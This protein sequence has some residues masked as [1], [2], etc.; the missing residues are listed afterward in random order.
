MAKKLSVAVGSY[1][2]DGQTKTRWQ[3]IGVLMTNDQGKEYLLL[4]ASVSVGGLLAI[5][6]AEAMKKGEQV[7]DRV[8]VNVFEEQQNAQQ[9]NQQNQGGYQQ[10]Q[11]QQNYQQQPGMNQNGS[12]QSPYQN[13]QQQQPSNGFDDTPF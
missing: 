11:P 4:D 9:Y 1:Q 10:Q 12:Q 13:Q 5:Q 3:N 7:R 6:N 2:K 8:M